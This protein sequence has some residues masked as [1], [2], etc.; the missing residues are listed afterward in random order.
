MESGPLLD[1]AGDGSREKRRWV[2]SKVY[3]RKGHN[4]SLKPNPD[5]NPQPPQQTEPISSQQTLA[6]TTDGLNSSVQQQHPPPLPPPENHRSVV[7]DQSSALFDDD[8]SSLNHKSSANHD[9]SNGQSRFIIISLTSK[10][11]HEVREL[12]NK[13]TS[14]L[15]L[16]RSLARKLEARQLQLSA[17]DVG[18]PASETVRIISQFSANDV[19]ASL[20]SRRAPAIS[21]TASA[22]APTPVLAPGRQL[23]VSVP[24]GAVGDVGVVEALE[25]EKRTP[26]ANQYY[27]NTDFLLGKERLPPQESN[28]KSKA[29]GSKNSMQS[30]EIKMYEP[31]FR[32]CGMLLSKLMKH[33]HGWVFNSPVDAEA[34]GLP[35]YHRIIQ[36]PMDLG[37]VKT[38]LSKNWYKSPREFAEDVR[39]T[40]RNAMTYNPKGQDVHIMAE[41]LLQIFE[42]RWTSIEV[43]LAYLPSPTTL[44]R[45]A[46]HEMR[47]ILQKSELTTYTSKFDSKV[48][49]LVQLTHI[50]RPPALKKPKA[51]DPN[52]RDMTFEEKQRLSNNL[53]KLPSEKLDIV[54]QIIRK[55]NLSLSQHEDEIEVD[56]DSVDTETLWELDRFVT[57]YKKSLSKHKRRAELAILA[58]AETEQHSLDRDQR[59]VPDAMPSEVIKENN[60]VEKPVASLLPF[61][62]PRNGDNGNRSSSSSSSS[63]DSASTSSDSDSESSSGSGTEGGHSPRT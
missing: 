29:N 43:D 11:K 32:K 5:H 54:V 39:L 38:R 37:T 1:G 53:Q 52:K 20:H 28:K 59:K 42:E 55:K 30:L 41:Q 22:A 8:A 60:A 63:S 23:S 21:E 45:P 15:E 16:V 46:P 24:S 18:K 17:K 12:R 13:L 44:K 34:L 35:D 14:E 36:H 25:K 9:C 57:N 27:K 47:K 10:G 56:I 33:N 49:P 7:P 2:E 62:G 6:T 48:K 31:A 26:K 40:F 19:G 58:R 50:G 3:T 61:G 51:K 4:K